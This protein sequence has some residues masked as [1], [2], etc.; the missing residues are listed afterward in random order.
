M[1]NVKNL[2]LNHHHFIKKVIIMDIINKKKHHHIKMKTNNTAINLI[3][4][5]ILSINN[6][7]II[8]M[9]K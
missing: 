6:M 5:K 7:L 3:N 8:Y 9:N 1:I 4:L 2:N